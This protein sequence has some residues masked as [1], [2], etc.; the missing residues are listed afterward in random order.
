MRLK[1]TRVGGRAQFGE[2]G[3]RDEG[4][5]VIRRKES[6]EGKRGTPEKRN[7][8][9]L[10]IRIKEQHMQHREKGA[11]RVGQSQALRG[12]EKINPQGRK[13]VKVVKAINRGG[14]FIER[15]ESVGKAALTRERGRKGNSYREEV[16]NSNRGDPRGEESRKGRKAS[17]GFQHTRRKYQGPG[18]REQQE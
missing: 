1:T 12:K 18:N 6:S 9:Q 13:E 15:K 10:A 2:G 8:Q 5:G 14:H 7:G 17:L 16:D 11:M 3:D 4:W